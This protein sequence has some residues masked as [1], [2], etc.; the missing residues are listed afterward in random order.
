MT[1]VA[2][3]PMPCQP[4]EVFGGVDTHRDVHVVAV[5]D[6]VGRELGHRA[7]PATRKGYEGLITW[8]QSFGVIGCVG[9]EGT[10]CYGAGLTRAINEA[11][12]VMVEVNRPDRAARRTHGKSDPLDAY[13]AARAAASGRATGTPKSQVGTV[14][15]IR[16]L[17][18]ARSSA[19]KARTSA[20][21]QLKSVIVTAPD[22]LRAQ[23]VLLNTTRLVERCAGLRPQRDVVVACPSKRSGQRRGQLVDPCAATKQALVSI[24][25]RVKQLDSEI[26][27]LDSDL[28]QLVTACAPTLLAMHGVGIE[29]AG[30]L[31]VTMGDNPE[32]IT[33]EAKLAHLCGV[34]P[35]PASSGKTCRH[36]LNR[37]GDR[38]ANAAIYRIVI[39][40]LQWDER[41]RIYVARRISEGRTKREIIRCLKRYLIREIFAVI[42]AD[43]AKSTLDKT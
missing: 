33:S 2:S 3:S 17:R 20:L 24:A 25:T 23:L 34:A 16:V 1:I 32:R 35:I 5:I 15:S 38:A 7:F 19:V 18:L 11:G 14:E 9:V 30:Q 21:V 4:I 29:V 41:T 40:R 6:T 10:G 13:S 26:K 12:L 42:Q 8:M 31:L 22:G 37:G 43:L 27:E 39:C 36:R 28:A